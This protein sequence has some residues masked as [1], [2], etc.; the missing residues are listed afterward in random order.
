ML[1]HPV[2]PRVI[3]LELHVP[4]VISLVKHVVDLDLIAV[5]LALVV[6]SYL[7]RLAYHVVHSA[8]DV[9]ELKKMNALLVLQEHLW[10]E[11]HA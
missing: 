3:Y 11:Q 2:S 4:C 1:A 5:P 6:K 10:M 7:E 9:Q 8:Q